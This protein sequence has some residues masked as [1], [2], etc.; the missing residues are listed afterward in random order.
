MKDATA[1]APGGQAAGLSG[2][3]CAFI[4]GGTE[5]DAVVVPFLREGLLAGEQCLYLTDRTTEALSAAVDDVAAPGQLELR[6]PADL[7]GGPVS[8][9]MMVDFVIESF[10]AAREG[11][12]IRHLRVIEELSGQVEQ[13]DLGAVVNDE[14]R[15]H[16][17]L[18]RFGG[19]LLSV[20][21]FDRSGG[22]NLTGALRL[23]RHTIV[24]TRVVENAFHLEPDEL[25]T[26][27]R[28]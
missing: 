23:H 26:K 15:L 12:G 22:G 10:E 21:D 13:R 28:R 8:P 11:Q 5:R 25:T 4:R 3:V 18:R 24:G 2:H 27:A 7:G 9:S 20:Y 14:A 17:C 16:E 1:L 6:S 19:T